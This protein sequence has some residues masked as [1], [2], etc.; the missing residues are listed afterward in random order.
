MELPNEVNHFFLGEGRDKLI[1]GL[2]PSHHLTIHF[3]TNSGIA[4]IHTTDQ[5]K[6]VLEKHVPIVKISHEQLQEL[7]RGLEEKIGPMLNKTLHS[8]RINLGKLQRHNHSLIRLGFNEEFYKAL[9]LLKKKKLKLKKEIDDSHFDSMHALP[10]Q[11]K[12]EET[13]RAYIVQRI[14]NGNVRF[15]G[16]I[17]FP[18]PGLG[19]RPYF[20]HRKDLRRFLLEFLTI[21]LNALEEL[22]IKL[23]PSVINQFER[24]KLGQ[25]GDL[26]KFLEDL[27]PMN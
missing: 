16:I 4:D 14:K 13:Q 10:C 25:V 2:S 26:K 6:S 1:I 24:Y 12:E 22:G 15:E 11:I 8:K 20:I 21:I 9:L 17:T 18:H 7:G 27:R 3:G 5:R 19:R 23:H